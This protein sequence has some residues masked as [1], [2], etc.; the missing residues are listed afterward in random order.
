MGFLSMRE[1]GFMIDEIETSDRSLIWPLKRH[2]RFSEIENS[3]TLRV[4]RGAGIT[5]LVHSGFSEAEGQL[6]GLLIWL[7]CARNKRGKKRLRKKSLDRVRF[8]I[9]TN[10]NHWLGNRFAI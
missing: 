6:C 4:R 8:T 5:R 10:L 1:N 7:Y 9:I 2:G 3:I